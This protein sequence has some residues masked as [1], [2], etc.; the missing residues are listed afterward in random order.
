M[1]RPNGVSISKF[2]RLADNLLI[3][4][5]FL[6]AYFGRQSLLFW[7]TELNLNLPL[8]GET[9]APIRA[10]Y[11]VLFASIIVFNLAWSALDGYKPNRMFEMPHVTRVGLFSSFIAFF[12]IAAALFLL[13]LD[14]SRAVILLFCGFM[15]I[16]FL[17]ERFLLRSFLRYLKSKGRNIRNVL[18]VGLGPQ[19]KKLSDEISLRPELGVN[20][21]GFASLDGSTRP[22]ELMTNGQRFFRGS[23]EIK[24]ALKDC[25]LDEV[26]F[27]GIRNH[28]D[29][30]E[31]LVIACSEQ[32]IRTT[33]CADLFSVGIAKS[34]V[35]FFG[36]IPLIH[37]VTPPGERW[38]LNIKRALDV[39]LSAGLLIVLSP[40]FLAI[41]M[42]IRLMSPGPVLFKQKR[43][44]LNG[45]MFSMYK[46]RSMKVG[47]ESELKNLIEKN[48]M[49]GP[50]FKMKDDP[51]ITPF[52][53]FL[54]KFSLDELPQ[55]FNVFRGDMS[56][57]GPRPPVPT[58]VR[59]YET[60]YRRRLSMRPGLTC[61]WQ[62]SGRNEI[63]DFDTWM[64]LDLQYID[65]WSLF[66]DL[67]IL[68]KTVPVVLFGFGAR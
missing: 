9:L 60:R 33:L 35:S 57:V 22:E 56:L 43:V 48:E 20:V 32:G 61:L 27:S 64:K 40:L 55:L 34:E 51:R 18:I 39:V 4:G 12:V 2:V 41:A 26:I 63:K 7:N 23:E 30:V 13:K 42:G 67:K 52:G 28:L 36:G 24:S 44:G 15:A 25:P 50:V 47:A 17:A 49:D 6:A 3:V 62:V 8:Q 68:L 37:Y 5:M 16:G 29:E 65:N 66:N 54:R 14:R 10:Y 31:D 1:L 11:V 59:Q 38:E 46:F 58:E 53:R 19:S 45:R 21:F